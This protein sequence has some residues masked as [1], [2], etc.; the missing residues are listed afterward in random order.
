MFQILS[1]L[2]LVS[3][4]IVLKRMSGGESIDVFILTALI[5]L[6]AILTLCLIHLTTIP[7]AI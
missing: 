5:L 3:Y 6:A 7:R 2:I 1:F 4:L